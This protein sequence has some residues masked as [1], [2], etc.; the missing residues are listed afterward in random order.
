MNET[1]GVKQRRDQFLEYARAFY[2]E[3]EVWRGANPQATLGELEA[4]VR[5]KRQALMG[6]AMEL[7]IEGIRQE[8][9]WEVPVCPVC[10]KKMRLEGYR[11]K[12][13][14]TLEGEVKIRRRYYRCR[15]GE[16][17]LFPPRPPVR[18]REAPP[19]RGG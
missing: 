2:E 5:E 6:K 10:G 19:E 4:V 16:A 15:C 7:V 18:D 13:V 17:T 1:S 3:L 14:Q 12:R 8:V 9:E 11:E